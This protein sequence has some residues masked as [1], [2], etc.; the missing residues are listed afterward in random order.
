MYQSILASFALNRVW[1]LNMVLLFFSNHVSRKTIEK[2][3]LRIQYA[4]I[5]LRLDW[6][7]M[8]V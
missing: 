5:E 7:K 6:K 1:F 8:I 2:V 3:I 4:M